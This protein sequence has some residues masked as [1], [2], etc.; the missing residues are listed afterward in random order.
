[1]EKNKR[2]EKGFRG[3]TKNGS[4]GK[5]CAETGECGR[6]RSRP[7]KRK[8]KSQGGGIGAL[9]PRVCG[10]FAKSGSIKKEEKKG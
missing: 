6:G 9:R 5:G 7:I 3:G 10:K 4:V 1:L 2:G 8:A